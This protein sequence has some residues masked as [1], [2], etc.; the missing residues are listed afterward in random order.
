MHKEIIIEKIVDL[1]QLKMFETFLN[2]NIRIFRIFVKSFQKCVIHID[3]SFSS[4]SL[5][6][7]MF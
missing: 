5:T 6:K 7:Q 4:L 1:V 3:D 2:Y